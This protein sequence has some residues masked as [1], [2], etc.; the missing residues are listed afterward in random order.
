[1]A[2][3]KSGFQLQDEK[4]RADTTLLGFEKKSRKVDPALHKMPERYEE[5]DAPKMA[6]SHDDLMASLPSAD[7]MVGMSRAELVD[8]LSELRESCE[9]DEKEEAY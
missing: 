3:G 8:L 5:E 4:E 6:K 1:M 9:G 7:E 2:H